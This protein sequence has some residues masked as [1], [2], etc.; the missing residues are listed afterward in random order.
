MNGGRQ[1]E[2]N[3]SLIAQLNPSDS[4]VIDGLRHPI[5]FDCL[6]KFFGPSFQMIFLDAAREI[7]FQRLRNRFSTTESFD[8]AD[9]QPVEAHID[10]LILRANTV[11]SNDQSLEALYHQIDAWVSANNGIGVPL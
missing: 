2:L 9:T 1:A 10:S 11:I 3:A 7:R 5:D 8:V 4:A 6:S